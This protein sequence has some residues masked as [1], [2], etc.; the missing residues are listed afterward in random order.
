MNIIPSR[1]AKRRARD[2]WQQG[3]HWSSLSFGLLAHGIP[4]RCWLYVGIYGIYI[5]TFCPR[6]PILIMVAVKIKTGTVDPKHLTWTISTH[7]IPF[8]FADKFKSIH[9]YIWMYYKY[10]FFLC[11]CPLWRQKV[12]NPYFWINMVWNEQ[13]ND[14]SKEGDC[15]NS[16]VMGKRV[17]ASVLLLLLPSGLCSWFPKTHFQSCW[18]HRSHNPHFSI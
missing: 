16:S 4:R 17:W 12:L 3:Q 13:T 2:F 5:Y 9:I 6:T 10:S 7:N 15:N 1:N 11:I 18:R 14:V 8:C